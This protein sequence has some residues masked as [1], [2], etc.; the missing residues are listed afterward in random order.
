MVVVLCCSFG[1]C[2]AVGA[3]LYACL[4]S[5]LSDKQLQPAAK[6]DGP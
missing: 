4:D 3:V 6:A 5:P 2:H 1:D